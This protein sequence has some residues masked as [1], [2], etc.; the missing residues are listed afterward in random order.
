M[1][2]ATPQPP[3]GWRFRPSMPT[4]FFHLR[5]DC[6][7]IEDPA[8]VSSADAATACAEAAAAVGEMLEGELTDRDVDGWQCEVADH[9]GEVLATFPLRDVLTEH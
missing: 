2:A 7:L 9:T 1:S 3:A 5:H 4:F 6:H 8:G